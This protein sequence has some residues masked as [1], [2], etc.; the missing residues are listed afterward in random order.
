MSTKPSHGAVIGGGLAGMLTARALRR[1][2]DRVTVI[3]RDDFPGG[4]DLRR[5]VPQAR[6]AHLLWSG[7]ARIIESLLPGTVERLRAAGAHRIGVQSDLVNL[8]P[9]GWQR[10]F[11]ETQFLI[12]VSRPL[13]DWTVRD[14]VLADENITVLERTEVHEL[15]GTSG[16]LT[17]FTVRGLD[18]GETTALDAEIVVDA[19][20]RGSR[21]RQWTAPLGVPQPE[22]DV[23][24][25]GITYSTRVYRAP[26]RAAAR[27]PMVSVYADYRSGVPGRSGLILPIEDGRWIVTLSG[28]R[29]GEPP[30]DEAGF[31][32]FAEGLRH[33]LVGEVLATAEPDGPVR[34]SRS[35]ANR[36]I[37]YDRLE[38]WPDN[39]VVL[40]DAFAAFNPI[41]GHGMSSAARAIAVL[42]RTLRRQSG[43]PELAATVMRGIAA[44]IDDPWILAASQDV[45]YPDCRV[46][47][48]DPR[49]SEELHSRQDFSE[50]IGTV[51][52]SDPLVS[53]ASAGVTTLAAPVSSLQSPAVLNTLRTGPAQPP[54]TEPPLTD[55]EWALLR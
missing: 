18:S 8:S 19:S 44:A 41:Y 24:D 16:H 5:G 54:L 28:T 22:E 2:V 1:H 53:A 7:G 47:A 50:R 32:A 39:L 46:E 9:Y 23:V 13:L 27:F 25:S 35:T 36:R 55:E 43:K 12:A 26:E 6:H 48:K 15:R 4:P 31:T 3:D 20:G 14:Q 42:D 17:G 52:L 29:G 30:T 51:G 34:G 45:F 10:R 21:L 40:G 33:P 37:H 49:L 38:R 11:P